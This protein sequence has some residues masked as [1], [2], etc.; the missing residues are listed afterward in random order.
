MLRV[1]RAL[2][3]AACVCW[4]PV[5]AG[6]APD[7]LVKET[8]EKV[9]SELTANRAALQADVNLLYELVDRIVLP[10]FDFESMSKLVLGKYWKQ[11]DD[12]QRAKFQEEF[13]SLLVRTYATA[14]FEYT[15]QKIVY[16]P[17]REK[18]GSDKALVQTEFVPDD[19]P[20]IPVDYA[21]RQGDDG[22]WRVYDV[23]IDEIS[24]VTNYR[25]SYGR[26]IES[27]GINTLIA[28]LSE[29]RETLSSQ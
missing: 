29:K 14:L 25:T 28:S 17:F 3:L 19:G 27:K 13:K 6:V 11:A 26:I 12:L 9:L 5:F 18:K 7:V 23:R 10:H 21:L 20:A 22:T 8:T 24:M 1:C 15:G 2:A 16:K 4:G